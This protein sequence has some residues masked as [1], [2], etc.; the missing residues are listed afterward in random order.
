MMEQINSLRAL[1]TQPPGD[2]APMLKAWRDHRG[3]SQSEAAERLHVSV[4]TLQGWESGR[5]MANPRLLRVAIENDID[6]Q[7]QRR[8]HTLRDAARYVKKHAYSFAKSGPGAMDQADP[9]QRR[10]R[11]ARVAARMEELADP[12]RFSTVDYQDF[13]TM[14][15]ELRE[16]G[17]TIDNTLVNAV[18][19]AF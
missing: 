1:L 16:I 2:V 8:A 9:D 14:L 4:R 3:L 6:A 7:T 19:G 13:E 10:K 11:A 17:F 5:P 12:A 18:A 15:D